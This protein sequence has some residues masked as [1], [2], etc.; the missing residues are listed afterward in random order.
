MRK[1]SSSYETRSGNSQ[2]QSRFT[3]PKTKIL[4]VDLSNVCRS[5]AAEG[6]L[7]EA[8]VKAGKSD[9]FVVSSCSTGG[10]TH[11]WFKPEVSEY[12]EQASA[13]PRMTSHAI[14]R[15]VVCLCVCI[16]ITKYI[17]TYVCVRVCVVKV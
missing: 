7:R 11:D 10:G 4:F 3:S 14:K 13:D 17:H 12:I 9:Q 8:L 1:R 2:Q 16:Y 6:T 15:G 5:A